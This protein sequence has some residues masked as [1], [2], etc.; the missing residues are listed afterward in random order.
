M[1]DSMD[2][3]LKKYDLPVPRYTSFPPMPFWNNELKVS[4]WID[5]VRRNYNALTGLDLY[6]HIPFC[7]S[8]CYYCGCNRTISKNHDVEDDIVDSILKEWK[9]Y[10]EALGFVP[11]VSSIH[12]GGGTPTFLSGKN[13]DKLIETIGK[14]RHSS[15]IGSIE[16]DPRTCK[17]EHL[18]VLNDQDFKRISLGIQDFDEDVQIAI[19]RKQSVKLVSELV[20]K[21]RS[22]NFE[23]INFD[24]IYG[25]PMQTLA[26]VKNTIDVV[27]KLAPDLIAF[28]SYAHLPSKIPNQR[29]ISEKDLARGSEKNALFVYGQDRFLEMG[30]EDIGMDH[31]AKEENYLLEAKREQRL[32]RNFMGYTDRKTSVLIG[33]GPSAISDSSWSFG[34]NL[35][36][37]NEYRASIEQGVLPITKG[38]TLGD[39]EYQAQKIILNL[40]CRDQASLS[41]TSNLP[42]RNEIIDDLI[43][44]MDDGLIEINGRGI[45]L[46]EVGKRFRRNVAAVFDH[47]LRLQTN[48][49][50]KFSQ[51]I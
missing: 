47:H 42:F 4:Q 31:F 32:L 44:F 23:S 15:F 50:A 28:Y 36:D 51:S 3:L 8:L 49:Q 45:S 37:F 11:K 17:D 33:L 38:H 1:E 20:N 22:L 25:L 2:A 10:C 6:I 41:E 18:R 9:I 26:T 21:I 40:M 39:S 30:Y 24:L 14:L 12:F 35:K 13:L 27:E 48:S 34:Q 43:S 5:D 7:E 29:L 46:T 16:I 19:N